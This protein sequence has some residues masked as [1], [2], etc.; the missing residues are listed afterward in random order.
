MTATDHRRP[1]KRA[2]ELNVQ[3]SHCKDQLGAL[4]ALGYISGWQHEAL[5]EGRSTRHYFTITTTS[6]GHYNRLPLAQTRL[7]LAGYLAGAQGRE[8]FAHISPY[9]WSVLLT[10]ILKEEVLMTDL[11]ESYSPEILGALS[12]LKG[13]FANMPGFK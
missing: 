3:V 5:R 6:G 12:R 9:D 7:L 11:D 8:S 4:Q 2:I 1:S 10:A 13:I